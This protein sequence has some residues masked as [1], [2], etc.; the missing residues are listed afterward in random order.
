L[1][2]CAYYL[3]QWLPH[4]Y[5]KLVLPVL[6]VISCPKSVSPCL[7][8]PSTHIRFVLS[9]RKANTVRIQTASVRLGCTFFISFL[10]VPRYTHVSY[11]PFS[12]CPRGRPSGLAGNVNG[13]SSVA[14]S[15][16]HH[17]GRE[18]KTK[19]IAT[20]A[21]DRGRKTKTSPTS[22]K[23]NHEKRKT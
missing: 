1:S 2:L 12:L 15:Y 17:Q 6:I 4:S 10:F 22:R 19:T 13:V 23:E 20:E 14:R 3:L 16:N 21:E 11:L 8:A 18:R 9:K 7:H 5:I